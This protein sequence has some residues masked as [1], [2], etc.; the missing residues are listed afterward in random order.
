MYLQ[1]PGCGV[2]N[3]DAKLNDYHMN[4]D[5]VY[6]SQTIQGATMVGACVGSFITGPILNF[7]RWKTLVLYNI[8]IMFSSI[9]LSTPSCITN[10]TL[11]ALAKFI[12][13]IAAGGFS[14]VCPKFVNET[15]PKQYIGGAGAMFQLV[16][17]TGIFSGTLLSLAYPAYPKTGLLLKDDNAKTLLVWTSLVPLFLSALQ[18][19]LLFTAFRIETPKFLKQKGEN[20]RLREVLAKIYEPEAI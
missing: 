15:A 7:G 10:P 3:Y 14:V 9:I 1:Y 2:N 8:F 17:C 20:E 6:F 4:A 5:K 13:G 19:L 12:F 11:L 16:V 18:T